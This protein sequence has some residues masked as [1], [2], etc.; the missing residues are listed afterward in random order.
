M[1]FH[2]I[3]N[4][5]VQEARFLNTPLLPW[6]HPKRLIGQLT[7]GR[8]FRTYAKVCGFPQLRGPTTDLSWK[9]SNVRIYI[10]ILFLNGFQVEQNFLLQSFV[11][12][13]MMTKE[14]WQLIGSGAD[15]WVQGSKTVRWRLNAARNAPVLEYQIPYNI[16]QIK[17]RMTVR[18]VK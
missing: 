14:W 9:T 10:E 1:C 6:C 4:F 3:V 18:I 13:R 16:W 8:S 5:S 11:A 17:D 2:K 7:D 12:C 15:G